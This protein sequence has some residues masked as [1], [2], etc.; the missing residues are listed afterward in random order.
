[1]VIFGGI[2]CFRAFSAGRRL[3]PPC[4]QAEWRWTGVLSH[5]PL[6]AAEG[7]AGEASG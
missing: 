3:A 7:S 5:H 1:V 4:E 2:L 6:A